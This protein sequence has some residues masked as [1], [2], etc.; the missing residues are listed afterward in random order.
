MIVSS[1][2]PE[3]IRNSLAYAHFVI[4]TY[5]FVVNGLVVLSVIQFAYLRTTASIYIVSLALTDMCVGVIEWGIAFHNHEKFS[6]W[7]DRTVI[8]CVGIFSFAIFSV[9]CSMFN[10]VLIAVDRLLYIT[11]PLF[12]QRI[13]SP[14]NCIMAV[15]VVWTTAFIWASIPFFIHTYDVNSTNP[16]CTVQ[17]AIP[18]G[19]RIY[20][21]IPLLFTG[22]VS[23]GIMYIIIARTACTQKIAIYKSHHGGLNSRTSGT[24]ADLTESAKAAIKA[25]QSNIKTLKLFIIVFGLLIVC[26]LPYYTI[27]VASEFTPIS[28][29]VYR[30]SVALGFFNSGVNFLVY[31]MYNRSFRRAFKTMLCP[32]YADA[33]KRSY[34][35]PSLFTGP[36]QCREVRARNLEDV[37]GD[38]SPFSPS[39]AT[40]PS[41]VGRY[42]MHSDT[43]TSTY[44]GTYLLVNDTVPVPPHLQTLTSTE[45]SISRDKTVAGAPA[46]HVGHENDSMT[47]VEK[48][49]NQTQGNVAPADTLAKASTDAAYP[50][51]SDSV[52]APPQSQTLTPADPSSS[53]A[54]KTNGTDALE[55]GVG[56]VGDSMAGVAVET[57]S[58]T[59]GD[60][61][62][63]AGSQN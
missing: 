15:L 42:P 11:R 12:Y 52:S 36:I 33:P 63:A 60:V 3:H 18:S 55:T 14:K 53:S 34:S 13:Q 5:T 16:N 20:A 39:A 46:I 37:F 43:L 19:F 30:G 7:F 21:N 2:A 22:A 29:V 25:M 59:R 58:E 44:F 62:P 32:C 38:M 1:S 24:S 8:A 57:A 35:E 17:K 23:T 49:A 9:V 31:P 48:T 40:T 54:G 61:P 6:E 26:W 4:G 51:V 28:D 10:M 27:E 50:L 45:E 47:G 56:H 41:E